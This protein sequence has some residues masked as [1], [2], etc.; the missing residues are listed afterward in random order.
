MGEDAGQRLIDYEQRIYPNGR[1]PDLAL[2]GDGSFNREDWLTVFALGSFHRMGWG[3]DSQHQRFLEV[4]LENGW[5]STFAAPEPHER[6]DEWI[7]VLEQFID[8]Q[9]DDLRWEWWM[10]R[11]RRSTDS[12]AG[13]TT[14]WNCSPIS[15]EPSTK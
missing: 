7:E 14:T 2:R 6:A 8:A 13:W 3:T 10:M 1:R 12:R 4:C 15:I 5:W 9:V 11:F